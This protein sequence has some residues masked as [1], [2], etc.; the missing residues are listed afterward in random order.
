VLGVVDYRKSDPHNP[1]WWKHWR[2]L[3]R[4]MDESAHEKLLQN[5]YKFQLALVSNS[6]IS[7]DD[8]SRVQRE[9]KELFSDI[10]G[11]LRPWLG[12]TKEDR[13]RNQYDEFKEQ[14]KAFGGFD[15]DDPEA[16]AEWE[17]KLEAHTDAAAEQ[18]KAEQAAE[19]NAQNHLRARMEE[20]RKKRLRQQGRK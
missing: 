4:A 6:R 20:V 17:E 13:G 15:L 3:V 11:S 2:Y 12:R 16:K 14:W 10:E 18:H 1:T 7:A 8:F 19:Q 5:A 9:A